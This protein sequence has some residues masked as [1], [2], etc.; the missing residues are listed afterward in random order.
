MRRAVIVEDGDTLGKIAAACLGN[1]DRWPQLYA[2]NW[3]AVE[4]EHRKRGLKPRRPFDL[5][6]AGTVLELPK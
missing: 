3:Q 5:I 2:T 1:A 6:F 4:R